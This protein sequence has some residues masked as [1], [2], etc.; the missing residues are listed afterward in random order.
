[1]ARA[2]VAHGSCRDRYL[3]QP[4]TVGPPAILIDTR[5]SAVLACARFGR[6]PSRSAR[7]SSD[8][9][10]RSPGVEPQQLRRGRCRNR[11][12]M[13]IRPVPSNAHVPGSGT[14][15]SLI[16]RSQI[17]IW[18]GASNATTEPASWRMGPPE[19]NTPIGR[20]GGPGGMFGSARVREGERRKSTR[21]SM[22]TVLE[23]AARAVAWI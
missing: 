1:L 11:R 9:F 23:R 13:T 7:H 6:Q 18:T 20:I 14:V 10:F 4:T 8:G 17:P 19:T 21:G 5:P 3:I 2:G 16:A 12:H 15:A 22:D